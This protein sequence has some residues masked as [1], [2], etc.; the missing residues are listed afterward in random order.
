MT[1]RERTT[2][3]TAHDQNTATPDDGV[4]VFDASGA[5]PTAGQHGAPPNVN[6]GDPN[7]GNYGS[8]APERTERVANTPAGTTVGAEQSGN[9]NRL[10]TIVAI[11]IVIAL[12]LYWIF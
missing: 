9:M 11:I 7:R 3:S 6:A 4:E 8:T 5:L 1:E 2:T 12:L 10:L